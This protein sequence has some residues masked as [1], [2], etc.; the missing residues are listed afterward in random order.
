MKDT[1]H[2]LE[3]QIQ[4]L[5]A[6]QQQLMLAEKAQNEQKLQG[7]ID[8]LSV[9]GKLLNDKRKALGIDLHTLELQT[10]I[11]V[12][13]LNRLFSDPSQVRFNTVLKVANELGITLCTL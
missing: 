2:Y 1:I 4:L 9:F 13:T 10:G 7:R 5:K 12:S 8:D 11:S 6:L 3:E